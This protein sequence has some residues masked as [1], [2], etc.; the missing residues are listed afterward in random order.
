MNPSNVSECDVPK[1]KKSLSQLLVPSLTCTLT[2]ELTS[3]VNARTPANGALAAGVK[4][5]PDR[6]VIARDQ[7]GTAKMAAIK[8]AIMNRSATA[9]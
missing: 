5:G 6:M 9:F 3:L 1:S 7:F 4:V 8:E 2:R